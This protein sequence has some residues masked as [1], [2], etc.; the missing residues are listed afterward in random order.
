MDVFVYEKPRLLLKALRT[1]RDLF[2]TYFK[3]LPCHLETANI[4][5]FVS[6]TNP[7]LPFFEGACVS[8]RIRQ[9][10]LHGAAWKFQAAATYWEPSV[11][12]I[13]WNPTRTSRFLENLALQT[14]SV[15]TPE[16]II[17]AAG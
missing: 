2:V 6:S 5:E 17:F 15:W 3:A 12:L 9:V 4:P 1:F 8:I 16:P 11:C 14:N 10:I 7:Q 13:R